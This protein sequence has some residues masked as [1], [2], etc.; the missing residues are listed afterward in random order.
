MPMPETSVYEND[1]AS[2]RKDDVGR[3]RQ[4]PTMKA[5]AIAESVEESAN[6]HLRLA[7]LRTDPRHE[8]TALRRG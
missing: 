1:F 3:T 4:V 6:G 8:S 2:G 5:I 7:V